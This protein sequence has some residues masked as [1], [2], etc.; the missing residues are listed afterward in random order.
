MGFR[1]GSFLVV[2]PVLAVALALGLMGG[3][4]LAQS[5]GASSTAPR[6]SVVPNLVKFNGTAKDSSGKP[7]AGVMGITFSLYA[8]ETGGAALWM[9]TQN[10]KADTAG[11][12][13]VSLGT[14]KALPADLF[15][16]GE[17]RWLGVQVAEQAEQPLALLASVPY[18][19]KA[20]DAETLGGKPASAFLQV[21]Q[22][23]SEPGGALA[24]K[25]PPTVHGNGTIGYVPLWTAKNIVDKSSLFQSGVNL[26]IG[27]TTPGALLDVNGAS[28][29][30][31]TLTLFPNG[32]APA[33]TL[34]GTAFS[35]AN[36][37]IITFAPGQTFPG[38]G[39]GT[40][41]GVTAGTGLTGGGTSGNVTLN[42]DTTKVP[43]LTAANTFSQ[44]QTVTSTSGTSLTVN[45]SSATARVIYGHA[46]NTSAGPAY[47][48]LGG[49]EGADGV[50]VWGYSN[51]SAGYGVQGK[52]A[53]NGVLG[54][55]IINSS[56]WNL[57]GSVGVH[58]DNGAANGIG[59][60]GTEDGGYGVKGIS[61]GTVIN[62]AGTYGAAGPPSGYGGIAGV[63]GDAANHVGTFGSSVNYSGVLGESALSA[64][65]TG[66]NN[67]QGY[68]MIATA[69]AAAHDYGVGLQAESFGQSTFPGGP[70]S[71]GVR[72]I[73]HTI[74]GSGVAGI[75]DAP[76]GIGVYGSAAG[77]GPAGYFNGNVTVVGKVTSYNNTP[78]VANGVASIVG[79]FSFSSNGGGN[80]IYQ[81]FYTPSSD[82]VY[83][84]TAFEECLATSGGAT[85]FS[86]GF[87][88][89][90]P[91]NGSDGDAVFGGGC[92]SL[93]GSHGS[94]LA[95]VKGGTPLQYNYAGM[96]APFQVLIMVEK[97]M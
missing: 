34:S 57:Y 72:G 13:N 40:I 44:P 96:D 73:T 19:L 18:A 30:R 51:G 46:T 10:V 63:W 70:G 65:V 3:L 36:N 27:T 7:L 8:Q 67:S 95:H 1:T 53:V 82:G 48:I 84:V 52:G 80:N 93:S 5:Q 92:L 55:P 47:G 9:E 22:N 56:I 76:G 71:D 28:N 85:H 37:G 64:G 88:W 11:R 35:V 89:K 74:N 17:A 12:Y 14:E 39:G 45:S 69:A 2:S 90:L 59:V 25:L 20:A 6:V 32:A 62:T 54:W 31:S 83:R 86:L 94:F 49:A 78:T 16:S 91:T 79:Q 97:L 21:L 75:N 38:G 26:G 33:L 60:L 81:T 43:L 50:G 42:L 87:S 41:T 29:L 58:G 66:I 23:Q 15:A 68:G 77:G 24:Q 61:D 4:A